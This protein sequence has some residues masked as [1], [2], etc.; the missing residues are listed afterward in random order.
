MASDKDIEEGLSYARAKRKQLKLE[1]PAIC[2]LE[3]K[4][5]LLDAIS[6]GDEAR[7]K[8]LQRKIDRE[9][10]MKMWFYINRSMKGARRRATMVVQKVM[11]DGTTVEST[12]QDDTERMI[13]E[14]TECRFQLTIDSAISSSDLIHQLGHLVETDIA[15]QIVEGSFGFPEELEKA[16]VAVLEEI[17]RMG[18]ELTNGEISIVISPEEFVL[19]MVEPSSVLSSKCVYIV[20][21]SDI[22][23]Y[24]VTL[25]LSTRGPIPGAPISID[26]CRC[27]VGSLGPGIDL[28]VE[29]QHNEYTNNPVIS[30]SR[31]KEYSPDFWLNQRPSSES[32][33]G[34]RYCR[35]L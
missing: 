7:A 2:R 20:A 25:K 33:L 24:L 29:M 22:V 3:Q 23:S 26:I 12:S 31:D 1:A 5:D 30:C 10:G 6:R 4:T 32:Q 8:T 9:N 35:Y 15:K 11:P 21:I 28:H 16:T 18:V 19:G 17:G 34:V 27:D 14:E 13:F